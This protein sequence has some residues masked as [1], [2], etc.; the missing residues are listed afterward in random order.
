MAITFN[1]QATISSN[2]AF[3]QNPNVP[4]PQAGPTSTTQ[5]EPV[6]KPVTGFLAKMAYAWINLSEGAKGVVK[7]VIGGL[8]VGTLIAGVDKMASLFKKI[9]GVTFLDKIKHPTKGLSKYGRVIAP[10]AAG[11]VFIA[12]IISARLTANKKT[13]NVDHQLYAGHRD[14]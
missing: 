7:G 5:Q 3:K 13:A 2:I 8:A 11:A 12:N 6:K 1:P 14:Q 4:A 9:D 10:I